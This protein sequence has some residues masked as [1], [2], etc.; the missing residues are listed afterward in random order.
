[1]DNLELMLE[2]SKRLAG[3]K[4]Y[5]GKES[6]TVEEYLLKVAEA[7]LKKTGGMISP[8]GTKSLIML[9]SE[10]EKTKYKRAIVSKWLAFGRGDPNSKGTG[11]EVLKALVNYK[12]D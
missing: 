7:K 8:P 11:I 1:M 2:V 4:V 10:E 6:I 9:H 12:G 5:P 3:V